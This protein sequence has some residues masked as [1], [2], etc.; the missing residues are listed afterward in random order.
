MPRSLRLCVTNFSLLVRVL[1]SV[2]MFE[3]ITRSLYYGVKSLEE[4]YAGTQERV[5]AAE[6]NLRVPRVKFDVGVAT[7]AD[8]AAAEGPQRRF[9]GRMKGAR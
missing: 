6:E 7:A 4:S 8:V 1:N 9:C 2:V 5:R 3:E